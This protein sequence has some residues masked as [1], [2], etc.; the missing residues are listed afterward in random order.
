MFVLEPKNYNI[1]LIFL[2]IALMLIVIECCAYVEQVFQI[3][4]KIMMLIKSMA[5]IVDII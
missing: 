3:D 5:K 1:I 2:F 4:R